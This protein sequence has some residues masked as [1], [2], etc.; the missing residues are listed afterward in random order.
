MSDIKFTW[1]VTNLERQCD[2]G[3][4]LGAA[5]MVEASDDVYK[6]SV[7]GTIEFDAPEDDSSIVP[8][9]DLT[10]DLVLGWIK[11]KLGEENT[12]K[13]EDALNTAV[14]EQRQPTRALGIPWPV[15]AAA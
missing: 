4:V 2:T 3:L 7:V 13:V 15:A 5:Y 9:F 11:E 6:S 12:A 10:Q 8:Y 14:S 1:T